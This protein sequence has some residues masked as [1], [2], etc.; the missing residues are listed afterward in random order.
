[1]AN[2]IH[3]SLLRQQIDYYRARAH[4]YDDWFF[5][6]GRYDRGE[7]LNQRWFDQVEQVQ[8]ALDEF[9]PAGRVLE[10]ACGTGLWTERLL[11][12]AQYITAID[13]SPEMLALNHQ[14]LRSNRVRYVHADLFHWRPVEQYNVVFFAFWLSHVPPR[15]FKRFWELVRLALEPDGRVFFID[16]LYEPTS[17]ARDHKLGGPDD[18]I[19]SRR[20]SDGRTY[21]IVKVF[22][23]PDELSAHLDRIGWQAQ[24]RRTEDYFLYGQAA[25]DRVAI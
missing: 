1:M 25:P 20:L 7:Q 23:Q 16:S 17:T 6:R 24:T 8:R 21:Q 11:D 12:H 13:A 5:R 18:T 4:E 2:D 19:A 15:R 3:D 22:Y 14:R 9:R 10:L